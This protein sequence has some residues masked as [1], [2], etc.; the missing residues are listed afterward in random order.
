MI[1]SPL[2]SVIK[3]SGELIFQVSKTDE[4]AVR[5]VRVGLGS[6]SLTVVN[7][8]SADGDVCAG[9]QDRKGSAEMQ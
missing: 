2:V 5:G 4:M 1:T 7:L 8:E 9:A 3:R 6:S